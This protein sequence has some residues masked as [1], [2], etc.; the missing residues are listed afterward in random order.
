MIYVAKVDMTIDVTH[1]RHGDRDMCVFFIDNKPHIVE[2]Q[3][4]ETFFELAEEENPKPAT[5][6]QHVEKQL[7]AKA[8]AKPSER[9]NTRRVSSSPTTTMPKGALKGRALEVLRDFGPLTTHELGERLYADRTPKQRYDNTIAL[10]RSM[11]GAVA[12]V[13]DNHL[14]K[15]VLAKEA[16]A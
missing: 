8:L 10:M 9:E 6:S 2:R 15:W 12:K 1:V 4:L 5:R 13:E 7:V 14:T 3:V 16:K 11:R